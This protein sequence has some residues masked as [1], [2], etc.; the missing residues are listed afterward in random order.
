MLTETYSPA[1][2]LIAPA[3]RPATPAIRIAVR[4]VVAPATPRTMPATDT[5]PSLAP[6]TPALSQLS[7]SLNPSPCGSSAWPPMSIDAASL[8][9]AFSPIGGSGASPLALTRARHSDPQGGVRGGGL[10]RGR[11]LLRRHL[12]EHAVGV[13]RMVVRLAAPVPRE[14]CVVPP[15]RHRPP[16]RGQ[17]VGQHA[18]SARRGVCLGRRTVVARPDDVVVAARG[19]ALR[20]DGGVVPGRP[21]GR[22]LDRRTVLP[23]RDV[24]NAGPGG[25]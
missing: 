25:P 3:T 12:P 23:G 7:R 17:P 13:L 10:M 6:S 11:P 19:C 2:M 1:A 21:R 16:G 24:G 5:M 15:E 9:G 8:M 4:S 20:G 18:G 14:R 22:H